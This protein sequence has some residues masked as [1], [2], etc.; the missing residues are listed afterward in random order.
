[1]HASTESEYARFFRASIYW[2]GP[3]YSWDR[4]KCP[5]LTRC[6][7]V[8]I[9]RVVKY[10]KHGSLGSKSCR[11]LT[12]LQGGLIRGVPLYLLLSFQSSF[13]LPLPPGFLKMVISYLINSASLGCEYYSN[14]RTQWK[15]A[16][17][18]INALK[19]YR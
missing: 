12:S 8:L 15:S 2:V 4:R 13:S 18:V 6:P 14:H 11:E 16:V 19:G 5:D 7:G 17:V 1:M 9:L 10:T 3:L